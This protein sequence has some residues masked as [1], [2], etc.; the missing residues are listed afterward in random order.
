MHFLSWREAECRKSNLGH[1][2]YISWDVLALVVRV[3]LACQERL[4]FCCIS[5]TDTPNKIIPTTAR[6]VELVA[7]W[8][9]EHDNQPV[10][11][12]FTS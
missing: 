2:S 7:S 6:A 11:W 1:Y 4:Q 12:S 3:L 10:S 9:R 8:G 5:T